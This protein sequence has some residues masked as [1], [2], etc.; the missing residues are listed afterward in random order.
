MANQPKRKGIVLAGGTGSRL[1]PLTIAVSKQL[2]PVYD[3]PMIYY[4]LSVLMLAEVREILLIST[5]ADL[6]NFRKLLGDGSQFG[7]ELSY[8]EQPSPEGLAQ[9]FP[10]A[11]DSGFL[12]KGDSSVLILGDNLFYG[13]NLVESLVRVSSLREGATV[14]GYHVTNPKD[15]GVLEFDEKNNVLSIEE[16]PELPKSNF[17]VP[18][19]Y[20]YDKKATD[21]ARALRPSARGELE[22]S[23]LNNCYLEL[24]QMRVELLGR[25]TA[26]LDTGS[27]S[28]LLQAAQ[29]V[30]VMEQR[31]GLK[32]ACLEE[33]AFQR[34]WIDRTEL[35]EQIV[36]L[37]K[38]G[39]S[40]YL[41]GLLH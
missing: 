6:P 26:W 31:Q 5:P 32:I 12:E 22:I 34:G 2:M 37:G 40:H 36:R 13:H 35:K 7:I 29:F 14:F 8:A 18:G 16:K 33:I 15:Y 27:Y 4:P 17:A 24:Q 20:F 11:S 28:S 23:D 19:L 30:E 39:Y 9:A 41:R 38:S 21:F 25:G 10:I 3:K 1:F